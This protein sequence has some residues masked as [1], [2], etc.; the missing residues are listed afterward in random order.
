MLVKTISAIAALFM[1]IT[2]LVVSAKY[3]IWLWNLL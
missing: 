1:L 2:L 3:A